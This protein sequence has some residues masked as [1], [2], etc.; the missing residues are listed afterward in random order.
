M[1]EQHPV[2]LVELWKWKLTEEL[3]HIKTNLYFFQ[4]AEL[5]SFYRCVLS[6]LSADAEISDRLL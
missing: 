6:F 5:L 3:I 2:F 1:K 4:N